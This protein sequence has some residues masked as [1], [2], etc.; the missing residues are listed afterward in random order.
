M[1]FRDLLQLGGISPHE[2]RIRHES[3]SIRQRNSA[4]LLYRKNGTDKVLVQ[5]HTP[6]YSIHDDANPLLDHCFLPARAASTCCRLLRICDY[7]ETDR[8]TG[9]R[10]KP[11]SCAS[12]PNQ[13][14]AI[15][16]TITLAS[17]IVNAHG[18]PKW[19][20]NTNSTAVAGDEIN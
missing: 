1:L 8:F 9:S 4:L 5:S 20:R 13:N 12:G 7:A 15:I 14:M 6:G 16:R 10:K 18:Y 3:R 17:N 19:S 2:Y 11:R